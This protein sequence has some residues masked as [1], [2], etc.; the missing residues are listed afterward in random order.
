MNVAHQHNSVKKLSIDD[1]LGPQSS[2]VPAISPHTSALLRL[3]HYAAAHPHSHQWLSAID[4]LLRREE[5]AS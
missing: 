1:L 2:R 5:E 4:L 3:A